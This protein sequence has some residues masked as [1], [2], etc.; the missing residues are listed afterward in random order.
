M[1]YSDLNQLTPTVK[2]IVTDEESVYQSINNI[3]NTPKMTRLFN[4]EFGSSLDDILF[5]PMDEL[6]SLQIFHL[7]ITS[8]VLWDKRVILNNS[9][10][11]ITPDYDLYRYD[12]ELVFSIL[13]IENDGQS[14]EFLGALSQ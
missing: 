11:V 7:V 5:E 8:I 1:I 13:G 6:T 9:Q 3:L 4:P 12:A 2:P 10:S 14:F